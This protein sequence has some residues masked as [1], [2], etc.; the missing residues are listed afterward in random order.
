MKKFLSVI[1][2]SVLFIWIT[3][4]SGSV[5]IEKLQIVATL[6]PQYDFARY[7]AGDKADV[8]LLLAPGTES[9]SYDP[10]PADIVKIASADLFI[11]TGAEMEHWAEKVIAGL[12]SNAQVLDVSAGIL[13]EDGDPHIWTSPRNA[14]VMVQNILQALCAVAPE[15]EIYFKDRAQSYLEQL[16]QLDAQ[17]VD[18]VSNSARK[19]IVFG[20]R[21]AMRYFA[22]AYGL[23]C[24]S[25]FDSCTSHTEP[26]AKAISDLAEK[27]KSEQIP[28]VYYAELEEPKIARTLAAETGCDLLLLHSCHNV[29]KDDFDAGVTYLDLMKQNVENLRRGLL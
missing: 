3:G 23:T 4:C 20:S 7:I 25:A 5:K 21:F 12:E 26:S 6:F 27:I 2:V 16:R 18:L 17:L 14:E 9:H 28:V 22:E 1:L 13:I 19:E 29:S 11:Y 15:F 24:F 8:S 10:S